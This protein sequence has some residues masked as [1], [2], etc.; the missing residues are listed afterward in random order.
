MVTLLFP[1]L[2]VVSVLVSRLS[3][4]SVQCVCVFMF[5]CIACE[6][7]PFQ[8]MKAL[9]TGLLSYFSKT[10]YLLSY[11]FACSFGT[12]EEKNPRLTRV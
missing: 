3:C 1:H 10:C 4:V 7:V 5:I 8:L 9:T 6:C 2:H 11:Y 12:N